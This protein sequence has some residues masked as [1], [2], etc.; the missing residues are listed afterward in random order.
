MLSCTTWSS[1]FGESQGKQITFLCL[2]VQQSRFI[3]SKYFKVDSIPVPH[4]I[5]LNKAA[6][7]LS[8]SF[9]AWWNLFITASWTKLQSMFLEKRKSTVQL[10]DKHFYS[11]L[12]DCCFTV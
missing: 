12:D 4:C 2:R 6:E 8:D 9:V 5:Y 11:A 10:T 7:R 1:I 3:E